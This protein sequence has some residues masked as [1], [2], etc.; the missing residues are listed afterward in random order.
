MSKTEVA[1][2]EG[3]NVPATLSELS[4]AER[5]AIMEASGQG[6]VYGS[7]LPRLSINYKADYLPDETDPDTVISLPRGKYKLTVENSEGEKVTAYA[8]NVIFQPYMKVNC[9][10]AY[11][12]DEEKYELMSTRFPNWNTPV[13][14]DL[15][16][17]FIAKAYGREVKKAYPKWEKFIKCWN[18]TYGTATLPDAVD[19]HGAAVEVADVP[20]SWVAKGSSFMPLAEAIDGLTAQ[21]KMM[22]QYTMK[23]GATRVDDGGDLVYFISTIDW[24]KDK[25]EF[26]PDQM[27]LYRDFQDTIKEENAQILKKFKEAQ[28]KR[29]NIKAAED[30]SGSDLSD[31]FNI[32]PDD[33]PE[34][35]LAA[36]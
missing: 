13:M 31:D 12:K 1:T 20:C 33:L 4:S 15:G 14:D 3:V 7:L 2:I 28:S 23:L 9:Y 5:D 24:S 19:M 30:F 22:Q 8:K 16:N 17:E 35:M 10:A 27:D 34:D 18:I 6:V 26:G 32:T 29:S 25:V 11:N 21:G 36:G